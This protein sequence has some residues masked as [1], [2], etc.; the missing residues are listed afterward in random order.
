MKKE[1]DLVDVFKA[2]LDGSFIVERIPSVLGRVKYNVMD[3]TTTNSS[4]KCIGHVTERQHHDL[5]S[6][7]I[8]RLC[9]V[10]VRGKACS[11]CYYYALAEVGQNE[12]P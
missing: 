10:Q 11:I 4:A 5:F 2:L 6:K 9:G 12:N 3:P 1:M 8:I 7:G